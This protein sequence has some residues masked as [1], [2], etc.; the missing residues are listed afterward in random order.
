MARKSTK[1]SKEKLEAKKRFE[2]IEKLEQ[3]ALEEEKKTAEDAEEEIKKIA[4]KAGMFCGV[5]LTPKDLAAI[6]ELAATSKENIRIQFK[7][8]FLDKEDDK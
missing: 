6:V 7:L 3:E 8:Y 5:I 2:E 4:E 1:I